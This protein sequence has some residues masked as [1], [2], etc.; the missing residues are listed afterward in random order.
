MLNAAKWRITLDAD[1]IEA[2]LQ[3]SPSHQCFNA[4][5]FC[6]RAGRA[7]QTPRAPSIRHTADSRQMEVKGRGFG[8][9]QMD[10]PGIQGK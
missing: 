4:V 9:Y 1:R 6:F 5:R 2:V 10:L 3:P 8:L 7:F